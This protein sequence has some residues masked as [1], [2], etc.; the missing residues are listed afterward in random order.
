VE[1]KSFIAF[2]ESLSDIDPNEISNAGQYGVF[3][4]GRDERVSR[5]P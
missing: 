4:P 2:P 3:E 5:F 1:V